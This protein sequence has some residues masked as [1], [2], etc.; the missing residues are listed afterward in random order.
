MEEISVLRDVE[1]RLRALDE[2]RRL[3]TL[4]AAAKARLKLARE[5]IATAA[6]GS[7]LEQECLREATEASE[8]LGAL[9][10]GLFN[11]EQEIRRTAYL[12]E[13]LSE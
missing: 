3:R 6:L 9:Q 13:L 12:L 7:P 5:R 10:S 4:A 2:A 11:A 1:L 8:R